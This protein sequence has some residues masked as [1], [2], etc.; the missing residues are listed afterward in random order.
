MKVQIMGWPEMVSD[1]GVKFNTYALP[2]IFFDSFKFFIIFSVALIG[3]IIWDVF[4]VIGLK[5]E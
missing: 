3:G 5:L 2:A 1:L 4:N